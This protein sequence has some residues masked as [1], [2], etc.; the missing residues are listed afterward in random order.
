M[1]ITV[2]RLSHN[3]EATLSDVLLDGQRFCYGLEDQPQDGPKVMNETRIPAGT[4]QIK[5]RTEGSIH[6]KYASRYDF[7]KGML[8]LQDVPGFSWIYIHTGNTDDHTSGCLLVGYTK[9]DIQYTIGSSR[10]AYSDLYKAVVEA[11]V[12]DELSIE[13]FDEEI[14]DE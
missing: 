5:L 12:A 11:A 3:D 2:K 6:P 10:D 7:H 1:L 14:D 8:W 9:N 13:Y 4:Y